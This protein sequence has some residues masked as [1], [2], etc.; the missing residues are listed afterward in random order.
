M[1]FIIL[2]FLTAI[3]IS[4]VAAYF[5]L[6]GLGALF[7]ATFWGVVIMGACLEV[8]KIVATKWVH[9]NW[10][11]PAAPIYFRT[12]FCIF[13]AVLM[14]ITS[15]GIYGYLSKGHL[16]Q[17]APIEGTQIQVA[18]LE[19]QIKQKQDENSRLEERLAQISRITDRSLEQS[20]RAGLRAAS[21]QKSES[22]AV[23]DQI[24]QNNQAINDLNTKLVPL[25]V[26]S[27]ETEAKLGPLKYVAE[28]FGWDADTAVRI[29][30]VLIMIAFDPLALSLF[31]A[32]S[33]SLQDRQRNNLVVSDTKEEITDIKE[34]LTD[35]TPPSLIEESNQDIEK[36]WGDIA[37]ERVNL[38][39]ERAEVEQAI[40][41][42]QNMNLEEVEANIQTRQNLLDVAEKELMDLNE[43][44]SQR[45]TD[46][47]QLEAAL[48][49]KESELE[50]A[51]E[52][53]SLI[54]Q[55]LESKAKDDQNPKEKVIEV[56][57]ANPDI[58]NDI[59]QIVMA[60]RQTR[61]GL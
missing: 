20:G 47:S 51:E 39:M 36:A 3:A 4:S 25:K 58:I 23:Q 18:Q 2:I 16:E 13:I 44:L 1:G 22:K 49:H 10:R 41:A 17:Q 24:N 42:L 37:L 5:S 21:Q 59:V 6:V 30:I 34:E 52:G 35:V 60:M 7:E 9:A 15:L 38:E 14:T 29:I 32:A 53:L 8:G 45:E 56:L 12:L 55:K 50:K 19:T 43:R 46:L 54:R 11:N 26:A 33:I 57:E 48:A 61:P 40:S 27:A 31:I 28:L